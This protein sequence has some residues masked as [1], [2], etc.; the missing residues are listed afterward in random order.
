MTLT[1]QRYS[2]T[3]IERAAVLRR[4]QEYLVRV[5]DKREAKALKDQ[6]KTQR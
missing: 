6:G 1:Q 2:L 3:D 5:E 4:A